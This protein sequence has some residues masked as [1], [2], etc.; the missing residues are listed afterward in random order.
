MLV[1]TVERNWQSSYNMLTILR[2]DKGRVKKLITSSLQQPKRK[3]KQ[4]TINGTV[5]LLDWQ[6]VSKTYVKVKDRE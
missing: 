4:Y 1:L 6:N 3:D 2:D 5:Y